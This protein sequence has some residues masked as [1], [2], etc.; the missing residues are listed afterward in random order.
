MYTRPVA[1]EGRLLLSL[2]FDLRNG[3]E[4]L[5]THGNT[6]KG[7]HKSGVSTKIGSLLVSMEGTYLTVG[8]FSIIRLC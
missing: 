4:Q 8:K 6:T 1:D 3:D 7:N 5:I 2:L